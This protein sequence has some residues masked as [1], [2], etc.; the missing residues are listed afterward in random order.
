M[1]GGMCVWGGCVGGGVWSTMKYV[2]CELRLP[3]SSPSP[4]IPTQ[5]SV[6]YERLCPNDP[7]S[8]VTANHLERFAVSGLRT[9]CVTQTVLEE[10]L[11]EVRMCMR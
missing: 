11:Y 4:P 8:K 7:L 9:L 6:I 5:D 2:R 10:D 1:W 3:P